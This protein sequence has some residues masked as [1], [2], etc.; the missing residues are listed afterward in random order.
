[1]PLVQT[2][3]APPRLRPELIPRERLLERL[4]D[5]R[6]RRLILITGPAGYGKTSLARLG[7]QLCLVL[8]D[9]QELAD[10]TALRVSNEISEVDAADLRFS[11][12]ET[13]RYVESRI[14]PLAAG[15]MRKLFEL[16]DGWITALLLVEL[17]LGKRQELGEFLRLRPA[18]LR[19]FHEF[20]VR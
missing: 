3:I 17:A 15:Q 13:A 19:S 14:G 18:S 5:A 16:T 4:R 9:F 2:K 20:L 8:D 11:E 7:T 6:Q 10:P 1:M 12:A